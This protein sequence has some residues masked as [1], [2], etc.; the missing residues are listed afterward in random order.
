M[1][2]TSFNFSYELAMTSLYVHLSSMHVFSHGSIGFSMLTHIMVMLQVMC[3]PTN[4][5]IASTLLEILQHVVVSTPGFDFSKPYLF[6]FLEKSWEVYLSFTLKPCLG[7]EL[8][9]L[10]RGLFHSSC[11]HHMISLFHTLL[12]VNIFIS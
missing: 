1:V 6:L 4:R 11:I 3:N 7:S 8:R 12:M 2:W 5:P 9:P 10:Y